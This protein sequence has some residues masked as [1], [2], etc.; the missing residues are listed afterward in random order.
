[1]SFLRLEIFILRKNEV[2]DSQKALAKHKTGHD[3][4]YFDTTYND[5]FTSPNPNIKLQVKNQNPAFVK[6]A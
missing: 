4:H 1:V 3:T 6:N 5:D 2:Y